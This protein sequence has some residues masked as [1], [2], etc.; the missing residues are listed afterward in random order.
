MVIFRS[1]Q[2]LL[3]TGVDRA[4]AVA[5]N[6][7]DDNHNDDVEALGSC[8][9]ASSPRAGNDDV[10]NDDRQQTVDR[11]VSEC[12]ER[13]VNYSV[14]CVTTSAYSSRKCRKLRTRSKTNQDNG[15]CANFVHKSIDF[16]VGAQTSVVLS[17][18]ITKCH[19]CC[20]HP[21]HSIGIA[22]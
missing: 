6:D 9:S 11:R 1:P 16:R 20:S 14:R 15:L 3:V 4:V 5:N 7:N 17:K 21:Y 22:R 12:N 18:Q 2:R 13:I 10:D 19:A 8:T